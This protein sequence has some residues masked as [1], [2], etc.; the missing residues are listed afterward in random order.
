MTSIGS[1][2]SDMS[3]AIRTSDS[4]NPI[5]IRA[6]GLGK[7]YRVWRSP[8]ARLSSAVAEGCYN[9]AG[10]LFAPES[11]ISRRLRMRISTG[12]REVHALRQVELQV[13]RGEIV[14]IIGYNGSGKSTLLQI[15]A[16]TLTPSSG[17]VEVNGRVA[18]LL[19]L[20]SGMNPDFT[21]RENAFLYGA[22][23]GFS[24][25]ELAERMHAIEEFAEIG[26]FIDE[27]VKTYSTG[28][29]ARLAFSVLTQL[30]PDILI[31]DETLSVGDAYFQHKSIGLIRRFQQ[32]GKTMLVVSH[33]AGTI[34]TMC[35]RAVI[36]E[37]GCVVRAGNAAAVCDYYNAMVAKKK[38]DAEIRQTER[39]HGRVITRSGDRRVV[40]GDVDLLDEKLKP[41]RAFGVGDTARVVCA[42]EIRESVQDPTIGVLIRDR[43]GNDVFGTN[44]FYQRTE[45]GEFTAG[46]RCE[47]SFV[48]GLDLAPGRYS[49]T[50][51]AHS[52][53]SHL[54]DNFDWQDNVVVFRVMPGDELGAIG[55]ARLPIDVKIQRGAMT[56]LRNYEWGQT[57][58]FG[59]DGNAVRHKVSGWAIAEEYFTWTDGSEAIL[60]LDLPPSDSRRRLRV[61]AAG[62]CTGKVTEQR[63]EVFFNDF[64][65]TDWNVAGSQEYIADVPSRFLLTPARHHIRFRLPDATSPAI[66][67]ISADQRCL[68][69]CVYSMVIE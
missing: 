43:L 31:V 17:S 15:L 50:V 65:L 8:F 60:R 45:L 37:H 39:E 68:G 22:V 21:G 64:R 29:V 25:E 35:T 40:I 20:G 47:V 32:E 55:I 66:E 18:A 46:D 30:N 9:S 63:V 27:P 44:T 34:K 42:I 53:R 33:D 19:E 41:A 62:F 61:R 16:G 28:M 3:E 51:A 58:E 1:D 24:R 36:L 52:G 12:Y 7:I 57:I 56:L 6:S 54:S 13:G 23:L 67:G 14:G 69:I 59:A 38:S 48:L 5:A 49:V 2:Q 26:E 4:S 10:S 11:R